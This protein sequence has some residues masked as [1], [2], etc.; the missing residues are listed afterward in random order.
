VAGDPP[1]RTTDPY[2]ADRL[3]ES[4]PA[5]GVGRPGFA[6]AVIAAIV[7]LVVVPIL[8]FAT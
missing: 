2:H 3:P 1:Q 6:A 5:F 7:I 8:V 4:R